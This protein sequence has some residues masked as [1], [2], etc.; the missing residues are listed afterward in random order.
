MTGLYGKALIGVPA[1]ML[2]ALVAGCSHTP[3]SSVSV[4]DAQAA[5]DGSYV[6]ID[7]RIS[8]QLDDERF[9]V[10]DITGEIIAEIEDH[11]MGEVQVSPDATLRLYGEINRSS[12]E[13]VL[14]V[15]RVQILR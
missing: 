5:A 6:V 8:Q 10:R 3:T 14:E 1:A 7:A 11:I 4:A 15:E 13:S 12:R 9:L 2:I